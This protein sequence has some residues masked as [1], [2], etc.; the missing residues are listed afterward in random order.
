M[1]RIRQKELR[2]EIWIGAGL[3]TAFIGFVCLIVYLVALLY[4]IHR[5][6]F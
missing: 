3:A 2:R 6:H 1:E 5:F 4:I